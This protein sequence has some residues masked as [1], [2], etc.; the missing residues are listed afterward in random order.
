MKS[1]NIN[2]LGMQSWTILLMLSNNKDAP[3]KKIGHKCDKP[4]HVMFKV[5]PI[6]GNTNNP[7]DYWE[8]IIRMR[9]TNTESS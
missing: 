6:N 9:E 2:Q 4:I 8:H 7:I 1:G 3:D 5:L